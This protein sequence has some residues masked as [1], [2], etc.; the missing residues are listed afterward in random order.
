MKSPV[1]SSK[2]MDVLYLCSNKPTFPLHQ[3]FGNLVSYL[4][5]IRWNS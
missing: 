1:L 2:Q 3:S 5:A 4:L